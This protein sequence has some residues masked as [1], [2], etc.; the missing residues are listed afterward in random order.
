VAA[1]YYSLREDG[2]EVALGEV[3]GDVA[4]ED[5]GEALELGVP[6]GVLAEAQRRLLLDYHLRP[7]HLR[8]GIHLPRLA[9]AAAAEMGRIPP[10]L[11]GTGGARAESR[12]EF[13]EGAADWEIW[14]GRRWGFFCLGFL[15]SPTTWGWS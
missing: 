7:L 6:R 11:E 12:A 10:F 14:K 5:V 13:L 15:A 4:D 2:E 8:Q 1:V 9:A 3:E